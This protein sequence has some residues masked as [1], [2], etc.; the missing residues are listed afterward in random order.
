M[1][2][3]QRWFSPTIFIF[4]LCDFISLLTKKMYVEIEEASSSR[5]HDLQTTRIASV[6]YLFLTLSSQQLETRSLL[7]L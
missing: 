1:N 7:I 3:K 2:S 5:A 6:F 4:I